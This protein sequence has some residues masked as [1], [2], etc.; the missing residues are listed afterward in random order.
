ML[1]KFTADNSYLLVITA[2]GGPIAVSVEEGSDKRGI[3]SR[4][5]GNGITTYETAKM[6]S[7]QIEVSVEADESISWQI[8]A[9]EAG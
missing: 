6:E 8:V 7:G 5:L 9:V 3:F 4:P 2:T 1:S